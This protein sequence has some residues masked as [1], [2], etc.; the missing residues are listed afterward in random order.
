MIEIIHMSEREIR[1]KHDFTDYFLFILIPKVLTS[2]F[3]IVSV[4]FTR[5]AK[6]RNTGLLNTDLS[7]FLR[8]LRYIA[9][10]L[11]DILDFFPENINTSYRIVCDGKI[12]HIAIAKSVRYIAIACDRSHIVIKSRVWTCPSST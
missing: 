12:L 11:C 10:T 2:F 1:H 9:K 8:F 5:Y 3:S 4:Y 7:R 6:L